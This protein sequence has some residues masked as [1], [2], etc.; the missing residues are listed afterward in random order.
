MKQTLSFLENTTIMFLSAFL[1][2]IKPIP[3]ENASLVVLLN[4]GKV[5]N[6]ISVSNE[7]GSSQLNEVG[8]SVKLKDKK[9][10]ISKIEMMSEEEIQNRFSKALMASPK[11]AISYILYFK[12]G[13]MKLTK[14]SQKT[15]IKALK[16]IKNNNP[17]IVDIIG[18]TD[19]SGSSQGNLRISLKR[20]K[21]VKQ[22]IEKK[23]IN[24]HSLIAKGYGEEDL[25]VHTAD[26]INEEKNR[27]VEIFIK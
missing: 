22:L 12:S 10:A 15:L 16:A 6:A 11:K 24:I 5:Q 14:A 4:N 8:N 9:T 7:K 23:H 13:R 3:K 2:V 17:C 25:L 27:N 18:H 26:N 1:L 20:A 21:Y 19:T